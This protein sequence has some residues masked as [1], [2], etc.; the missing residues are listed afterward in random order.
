MNATTSVPNPKLNPA[1]ELVKDTIEHYNYTQ[2]EVAK[3]MNIS[4]ALLNG[5]IKGTRAVSVEFA[6]RFEQCLGLSAE[7]LLR[8]QNFHDYCVAYHKKAT[9]ISN[10]VV[11]LSH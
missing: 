10:E 7:W 8:T 2:A 11:E 6:L 1:S 4:T 5:V 3:A 9:K